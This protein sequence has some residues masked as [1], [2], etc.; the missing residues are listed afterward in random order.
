MMD[1]NPRQNANA[2]DIRRLDYQRAL[3]SGSGGPQPA[4][5]TSQ[6]YST[7]YQ[8]GFAAALRSLDVNS[9]GSK[10]HRHRSKARHERPV[11][12]DARPPQSSR[13]IGPEDDVSAPREQI[14]AAVE[15]QLRQSGELPSDGTEVRR[16]RVRAVIEVP[17]A[18]TVRVPVTVQEEVTTLQRKPGSGRIAT[19]PFTLRPVT[20]P[21]PFRDDEE[22]ELEP[23]KQLVDV[24]CYRLDQIVEMELLEVEGT[25]DFCV[26]PREGGF[27]LRRVSKL[28]G[29]SSGS[30]VVRHVG[31]EAYRADVQG[32]ELNFIP[33][34][35]DDRSDPAVVRAAA[36]PPMEAQFRV[37]SKA[38]CLTHTARPATPTP[39]QWWTQRQP[40]TP[41]HAPHPHST[42]RE[43]PVAAPA[44]PRSAVPMASYWG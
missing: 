11:L 33:I 36:A 9:R 18:R 8:D 32:E 35:H 34:E 20:V 26:R 16:M 31:T 7:G 14:V 39:S 37:D 38:T 15:Q 42:F 43:V 17:R 6:G 19:D 41:S 5:Q 29:G 13:L 12:K 22:N 40:L 30:P 3:S 21:S 24:Q 44:V 1:F 4:A 10:R 27:R 2:N 28:P 25:Q 23:V